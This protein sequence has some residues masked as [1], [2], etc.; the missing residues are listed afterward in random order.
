MFS[1]S[2]ILDVVV[3]TFDGPAI[4]ATT[5]TKAIKKFYYNIFMI[6]FIMIKF[7]YSNSSIN[8]K[9]K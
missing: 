4:T 1:L 7:I 5:S 8:G 6:S 3:T 2:F 9:L